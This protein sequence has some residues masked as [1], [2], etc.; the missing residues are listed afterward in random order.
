MGVAAEPRALTRNLVFPDFLKTA[1]LKPPKET[2]RLREPV[3]GD[4]GMCSSAP[5]LDGATARRLR[6]KHS[7]RRR[8]LC[9][10]ASSCPHSDDAPW[11]L[12]GAPVKLR[13]E[14]TVSLSFVSMAAAAVNL[15]PLFQ[16]GGSP[17]ACV[18]QLALNTKH[19]LCTV[20]CIFFYFFGGLYC[21]VHC[22]IVV[23]NHCSPR[24]STAAPC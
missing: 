13:M 14:F 24:K 6:G 21:H 17:K 20:Y 16:P 19:W 8:L 15:T 4:R 23:V 1:F 5:R 11:Q 18:T 22:T 12:R 2:S 3:H 9:Q 10:T 7:S